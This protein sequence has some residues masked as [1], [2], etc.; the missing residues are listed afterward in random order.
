MRDSRL[1]NHYILM[2]FLDKL[3]YQESILESLK[4][5]PHIIAEKRN[6]E[7]L[8]NKEYIIRVIIRWSRS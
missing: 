7:I 2:D 6:M 4:E 3:L 8:Q 1:N 5:I